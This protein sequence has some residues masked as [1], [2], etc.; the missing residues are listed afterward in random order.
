M[1]R[2]L[3]YVLLLLLLFSCGEKQSSKSSAE[4]SPQKKAPSADQPL[5]Q[6]KIL[7]E[8]K[9]IPLT[10]DSLKHEV[11]RWLATSHEF[12]I[13]SL[14]DFLLDVSKEKLAFTFDKCSSDPNQL[15]KDPKANCV[16]Y[17]A[18]FNSL[19]N[20]A[21][22]KKKLSNEY[23][24]KHYVGKIYFDGSN[25]NA[26]FNDPFFRDHDFDVIHCIKTREDIAVDPSLFDYLGIRRVALKK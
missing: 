18:F 26:W 6:Y 20:Y 19:M 15:R 13:D 1:R 25:V 17:A 24:C 2:L 21:L 4:K 12:S 3:H 9:S 23:S 5:L 8:R 16:G 10:D 7:R 11:D 14:A 22:R